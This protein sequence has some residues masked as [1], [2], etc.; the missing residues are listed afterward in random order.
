MVASL[1][2]VSVLIVILQKAVAPLNKLSYKIYT[3]S[4]LLNLIC[5]DI[6]FTAFTYFIRDRNCAL[7][8]ANL[9][10]QSFIET[11]PYKRLLQLLPQL[12]KNYLL[13]S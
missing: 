7:R 8:I 6:N 1:Q 13:S 2:I 3:L 12:R 4:N 11:K 10:N 9:Q 5:A